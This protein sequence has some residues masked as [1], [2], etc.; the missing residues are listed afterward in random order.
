MKFTNGFWLLQDDVTALSPMEV[1]DSLYE[2]NKLTLYAPIVKISGRGDTLNRPQL[3]VELSAPQEDI[4]KISMYH[5]AGG[6]DQNPNFVLNEKDI[7]P[8]VINSKEQ[9]SFKSGELEFSIKDNKNWASEIKYKGK[10]LTGSPLKGAGLI[11]RANGERYFKEQLNLDV[12]ETIYGLGERFTPFVK[13][14]Q[15]VDIWNEDGGTCSEQAYKNIPFYLSSKGYG[16]LVNHP[17]KVS[18][19]V[20]SEVVSRVQFSV[21]GEKLEYFI[22]GGDSLKDVLKNYTTLSGKPGLPP[23]WSF[24]LWLTTSFTTTYDEKTVTSFIDGMADRDIP[25]QVFHFDCFWM[26]EFEWCNFKWDLDQFPEPEAMLKRLKNKGLYNCLWINS[27]IAQK[28]YMFNQGKEHGYLVKNIDG[29]VWQTDLWQAGMGLV[30]FTNPDAVLWYKG[31]LKELLLM[32]VDSFKADFGERIPTKGIKYFNGS[33]PQKMHNFYTYLY[34]KAVFEVIQEVKGH[35]KAMLFARSATVGSQKFPVHW[36]GDCSATYQSM[37]ETLRGG[38]S[39]CLSGF[40]FW[41][42]DIGGFEQTAEA[43]LYKRWCAFGLLS[44]HSR[45][46]G[47]ESYRVPWNFDQEAVDVLR[48]FT[49]LKNSLMPYIYTN[50]IETSQTGIPMMRAMVLEFPNDPAC[51]FLDTQYM[52]GENLL[53]APIFNNRGDVDYYLPEGTWTSLIDGTTRDGGKWYSENYNYLSLPLMVKEGSVIPVNSGDKTADY[54]YANG[55]ILKTYNFKNGHKSTTVIKESDGS[56]SLT[57]DIELHNDNIIIN[58]IGNTSNYSFTYNNG[59]IINL[60]GKNSATYNL[61]D[62]I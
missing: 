3:T 6:I 41:S 36:G 24:G 27:Y 47:S 9:I 2:N 56:T 46:H 52:L 7:V 22:I 10:Y 55:V 54:I 60:S 16:I 49:K 51:K 37:A 30:D 29:S 14:G 15:V 32:G 35:D 62:L 17:E 57:V 1:R 5:F 48:F 34:N 40:G 50:A 61:K 26:K 28:S 53:V 42:H 44:S 11:T 59:K 43:D 33:D 4:I 8:N 25:L 20:A 39:L 19:E 18:F 23:A 12:S 45:L 21:P 13:N 38:L 31:K 58:S